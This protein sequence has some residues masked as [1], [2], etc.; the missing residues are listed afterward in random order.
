MFLLA[1]LGC[2]WNIECV[3][4]F[5]VR[6]ISI[7]T[8]WHTGETLLILAV[9]C[10]NI[11]LA[12]FLID[13]KANVNHTTKTGAT[14]CFFAAQNNYV[15]MMKLLIANN[16]DVNKPR[17]DGTTPFMIAHLKNFNEII[18]IMME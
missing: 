9:Q 11:S 15:E 6:Y 16:A 13:Q 3:V 7:D 12:K 14:C 2:I 17:N 4:K 10:N 18:D 8:Q 5:F 1:S